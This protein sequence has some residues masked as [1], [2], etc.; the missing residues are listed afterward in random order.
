[1]VSRTVGK[2]CSTSEAR[3][4][5]FFFGDLEPLRR[6]RRLKGAQRNDYPG[7]V[8]HPGSSIQIQA[9]HHNT[10]QDSIMKTFVKT[11][12]AAALAT[13]LVGAYAQSSTVDLN[14]ASQVQAGGALNSQRA[15]VGNAKGTGKTDVKASKVNQV[16]AGGALNS[17]SLAIGNA[18]GSAKSKVEANN[19]NQVQAGGALNSQKMEL[20]SATGSAQST[21][22]ANNT[23]QV[24]A[25]GALN[26]QALS[27]GKATS[28]KSNVKTSNVTQ[29]QAG[30][31]LNS[32]TMNVGNAGQ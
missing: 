11:T 21:V 17:Q 12:V 9:C 26:S 5:S 7:T 15:D 29:V 8:G 28:G 4:R 1:V 20:G 3:V 14:N 32:Q 27:I 22:Q 18:E 10:T 16:Q 25:G 24:Q 23:S 13:L 6:K 19:V 31:A 30:G 2:S